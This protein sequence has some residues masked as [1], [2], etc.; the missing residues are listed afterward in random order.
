[1]P[2]KPWFKFYPHDWKGDLRLQSCSLEARGAMIDIMC[3]MHEGFPYGTLRLRG[4]VI[5]PLIRGVNPDLQKK[6][7]SEL[8]EAGCLEVDE[9]GA[10][11]CPRM[12]RDGEKSRVGRENGKK[13][14]NPNLRG[15]SESNKGVNPLGYPTGLSDGL[16]LDTRGQ[17]NKKEKTTKKEKKLVVNEQAQSLCD[18]FSEY[19]SKHHPDITLKIT[20]AT[21]TKL[22]RCDAEDMATVIR[23]LRDSPSSDADFWRAKTM[24]PSYLLFCTEANVPR[25][26]KIKK[27]IGLNAR[28]ASQGGFRYSEARQAD[29]DYIEMK[30]RERKERGE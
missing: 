28:Q 25:F 18:L 30:E 15:D 13:G 11:F 21:S 9:E 12:V 7:V 14:G 17:N 10:L 26:K 29:M 1:M 8:L 23:W 4:R 19:L 3:D 24:N 16:N 27:Q 6:I 22:G 5:P 2:R 20:Q